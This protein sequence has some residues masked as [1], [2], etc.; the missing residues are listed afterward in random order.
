MITEGVRE[1]LIWGFSISEMFLGIRFIFLGREDDLTKTEKVKCLAVILLGGSLSAISRKYVLFSWNTWL[2]QIFV[3]C[4][5]LVLGKHKSKVTDLL[6]ALGYFTLDALLLSLFSFLFVCSGKQEDAA[7][8]LFCMNVAVFWI[9]RQI[10][11]VGEEFREAA[12]EH[13]GALALAVFQALVIFQVYQVIYRERKMLTGKE[14]EGAALILIFMAIVAVAVILLFGQNLRAAG[15]WKCAAIRERALE[16]NYQRLSEVME[17]KREQV[18][19]M[20]HHLTVLA[21]LANESENGQI[22]EYLNEMEKTV[23]SSQQLELTESKILNTILSRKTEEFKKQQIA[24]KIRADRDFQVPLN[25]GEICTVYCNLL[26][27]A[28]EACF[29]LP[30]EERRIE[31]ELI[32]KNEMSFTVIENSIAGCPKESKGQFIS[33]KGEG[34]GLGLRSVRRA[35]RR[36]QGDLEIAYTEEIFRVSVSFFHE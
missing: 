10:C 34:H 2:I 23:F 36:H 22:R 24:F 33:E 32:R 17:E 14:L 30:P 19:D 31:M 13:A 15:A 16:E 29:G 8:I 27:N 4:L 7:G 9:E 21:E 1:M 12:E 5:I 28:A 3:S 26:D 18:H 25:D 11:L 6:L 20:R 35:V